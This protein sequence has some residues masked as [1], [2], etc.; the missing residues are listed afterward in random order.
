MACNGSQRR[1]SAQAKSNSYALAPAKGGPTHVK[2]DAKN[3]RKQRKIDNAKPFGY[4][5]QKKGPNTIRL[6][7][8]NI[9]NIATREDMKEY[10]DNM[11][12]K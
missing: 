8:Q 2:Q 10:I 4:K 1:A 6:M 3:T 5:L 12:E 11:K 9:C 7:Y